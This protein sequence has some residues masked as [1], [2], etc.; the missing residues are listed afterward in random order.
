MRAM[1]EVA[2]YREKH[3]PII[4][5]RGILSTMERMVALLIEE[6]EGNFPLAP[7]E[8]ET[9]SSSS[10]WDEIAEWFENTGGK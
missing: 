3:Q 1:D 10:L 4:V 8:D 7:L 2:A 5:H 9:E 6:Y